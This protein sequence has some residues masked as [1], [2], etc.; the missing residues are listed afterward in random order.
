MALAPKSVQSQMM[1]GS[2][3]E[4]L[5]QVESAR[6]AYQNALVLAQTIEPE[7]QVRSIPSIKQKLETIPK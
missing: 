2:V 6:A 7:F 3:F 5:G 4:V 1:L